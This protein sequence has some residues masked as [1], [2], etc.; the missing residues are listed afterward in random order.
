M[1]RREMLRSAGGAAAVFSLLGVSSQSFAQSGE[2]TDS[3]EEK[4]GDSI[5]T[6]VA[7]KKLMVIGAHPDDPELCAGGTLI[8]FKQKG[9]DVVSL[10]LTRGERGIPDMGHEEAAA[11]RM[12]EIEAACAVTGSRYRFLSHVDGDSQINREKYDEIKRV[13]AEEKPDVVIT[14]WPIDSHRDHRVCSILS[15]DAW[16]QLDHSFE[17]YYHEAMSGLQSQFFA[18]TDYVDISSVVELKHKACWCHISQDPKFMLE[19]YHIPMEKMRGIEAHC[20]AAEAFVHQ[21]WGQ[22]GDLDWK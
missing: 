9:W 22:M 20:K 6:G 2:N 4:G 21:R 1:N 17:L 7:K 14:H 12:K 5:A 10:Y 16:R 3:P 15:Y 18:P 13:I 11:V 8:L 19:E